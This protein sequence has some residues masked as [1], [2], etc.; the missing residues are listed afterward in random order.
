MP[1]GGNSA[2][3]FMKTTA[4]C[5]I[6]PLCK[7]SVCLPHSVSLFAELP[8]SVD[9][10]IMQFSIF[11]ENATEVGVVS[12]T[13]DQP[14]SPPAYLSRPDLYSTC[15]CICVY[16]PISTFLIKF[17]LSQSDCNSLVCAADPTDSASACCCHCYC[18]CCYT[19]SVATCAP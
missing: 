14:A 10:S 2:R 13:N 11:A 9:P 19:A 6:Q 8:Q 4:A 18:Y 3:I 7:Q 17:L 12:W 16:A 1:K 5:G 15:I